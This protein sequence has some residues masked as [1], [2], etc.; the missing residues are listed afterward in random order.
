M[1][2]LTLVL[3]L[4][5]LGLGLYLL[6]R[7]V[8]MDATIANVITGVVIVVAVLVSARAFGACGPGNTVGGMS[9]PQLR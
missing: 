8:P 3:F 6:K 2:I 1:T 4:A 7:F 9:V 5:G